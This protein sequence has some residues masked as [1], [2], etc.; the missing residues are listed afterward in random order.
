M[1]K[2]FSALEFGPKFSKIFSYDAII[3]EGNVQ[4]A[5]EMCEKNYAKE[6]L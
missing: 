6:E 1:A 5:M 3:Y 2:I 4:F